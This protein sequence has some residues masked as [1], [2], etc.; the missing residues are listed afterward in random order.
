MF[1]LS[2]VR[3]YDNIVAYD[4]GVRAAVTAW[5]FILAHCLRVER[6]RLSLQYSSSCCT[7]PLA[8]T[9]DRLHNSATVWPSFLN[10]LLL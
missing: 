2:P 6:P 3:S 9:Y 10:Y 4:P 8:V 7:I 5:C 1:F